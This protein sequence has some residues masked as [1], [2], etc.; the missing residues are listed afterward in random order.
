MAEKILKGI[1]FPGL[2]D[3][4]IIPQP[5]D[6]LTITGAPADAKAVGDALSGKQPVGNYVKTINGNAPDENGNVAIDVASGG[7]GSGEATQSD[8]NQTDDTAVDFIKNKPF[9]ETT[10]S[11]TLI[12]G[13]YNYIYYEEGE[14]WDVEAPIP[15]T[16]DIH[17]IEG[18]AYTVT[19]N[20]VDYTCECF[21]VQGVCAVGN[22]LYS[23]GEDNGMPFVIIE[24]AS[25]ALVGSPCFMF[26][27]VEDPDP[28]VST[29]V[30]YNIKLTFDGLIV[31]KIPVVYLDQPDWNQVDKSNGG[32][33]KN[34][35]FGDLP[36]GTI[37]VDE[38]TVT[39]LNYGYV[40]AALI[41]EPKIGAHSYSVEFDGVTHELIGEV[42]EIDG[43]NQVAL[44]YTDD[45]DSG[46]SF[47]IAKNY[48]GILGDHV[49]LASEGEHT[50]K[51][52]LVEDI[53]EKIDSKYLPD[54][55][56]GSTGS[57]LPSVTT[58]DAG[59]FLRVSSDGIWAAET[60]PSAEGVGF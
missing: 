23:G 26:I 4:Y 53:I 46:I 36:A 37:V 39:C 17:L 58:A 18:N 49:L 48:N 19:W 55:I 24:D 35:P 52:T 11:A 6:T 43:V 9:G 30:T 8:W 29:S 1:N 14:Y 41:N 38:T 12:D 47:T 10:V 59:K 56:G 51:I 57:A 21:S 42:T 33:I 40:V 31:Q 45:S 28:T 20:G 44:S 54:D 16:S 32:Y 15:I 60:I 13:N 22:T 2:E 34:R 25:G 3:T 50:F 5:D 7:S 27:V